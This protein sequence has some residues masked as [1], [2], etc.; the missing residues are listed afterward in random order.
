MREEGERIV[1]LEA[2]KSVRDDLFLLNFYL[3]PPDLLELT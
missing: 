3:S 2:V 1:Y